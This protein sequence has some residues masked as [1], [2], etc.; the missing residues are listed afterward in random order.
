MYT[1]L[2][3]FI[4]CAWNKQEARN[5]THAQT[6]TPDHKQKKE[7]NVEFI[8]KKLASDQPTSNKRILNIQLF[9][10]HI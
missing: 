8:E 7:F 6:D 1:I 2:Y 9:I 10:Y 3:I 5:E 4:L